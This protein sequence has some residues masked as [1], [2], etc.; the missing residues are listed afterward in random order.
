[1]QSGQKT[2][3]LI[4]L[5]A[6]IT[7]F[8]PYGV[9]ADFLQPVSGQP[10]GDYGYYQV[11]SSPSGADVVFDGKFVGETPI[12][13]PVFSSST[14]GHTLSVSKIGYITWTQSFSQNPVAG[15][16]IPVFAPLQPTEATGSIKVVTSPSGA[17]VNLDGVMGQMSPWIYTSVPVGGHVVQ[18]FLSGFSPHSGPAVVI[19][20]QTTEV[21]I[22]L[23][24]LTSTGSLQ[25]AT[26]PGGA[27]LYLDGIYKG[28]TSTAVGGIATGT[29][30]VALKHYGYQD[31]TGEV[32]VEEG[33]TTYLSFTLIPFTEPTTG[34]LRI[35]SDPAGAGIYIDGTYSG[36]THTGNPTVFTGIAPGQHSVEL[37]MSN[38]QGYSDTVEIGAGTT[39]TIKADLAPSPNPGP[40][41]SLE[42]DSVPSGA[43][44][45]LDDHIQGITPV[46][47]S[48]VPS[49][50]HSISI[51][52][53]GYSD[54]STIVQ[55]SPGQSA[56]IST[57]LAP[58]QTPVPTT[59]ASSGLLPVTA[60]LVIA[61]ALVVMKRYRRCG[62]Q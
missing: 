62:K 14:P 8:S 11:G 19:A 34:N 7:L 5:I 6:L 26:S 25:V 42:I 33:K 40:F 10:S 60:A 57:A 37:K 12:T 9:A 30:V 13:V 22:V 1:M 44:V 52:M 53:T 46:T 18:A 51:R 28:K 24:P 4:F 21:Y 32:R 38:Y 56:L 31:L 48:S 36:V 43:S 47:I 29:H 2:V 54:Y 49:G 3:L 20:G 23:Y 45:F 59:R 35:S 16:T 17:L 58:V 61:A 15:Q 41:A 55:L 50:R 39:S 27:D